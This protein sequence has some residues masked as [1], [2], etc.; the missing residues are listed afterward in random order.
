MTAHDT[1]T[2]FQFIGMSAVVMR[3]QYIILV[4]NIKGDDMKT[5]LHWVTNACAYIL[6]LG[7]GVMLLAMYFDVWVQ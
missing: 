5:L 2:I 6:M 4:T 7:L 1:V 3:G